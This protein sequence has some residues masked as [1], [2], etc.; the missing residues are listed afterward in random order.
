M[1]STP[2]P[3]PDAGR[4]PESLSAKLREGTRALHARAERA[5]IMP[6]LLRGTIDR[7]SYCRLLWCLE[8]IYDRLETLLRAHAAQGELA[9]LVLPDLFR[10]QALRSDL[11][12]LGSTRP[13]RPLPAGEA[14]VRRLDAI[15]GEDPGLLRAHV[16]V[17]YLGDLSGG[18]ILKRLVGA[19]PVLC[20]GACA[21]YEFGDAER[22]RMLVA[23]LRG[24]LEH[25]VLAP[26]RADAIVDEARRAFAAHVEMF[27]ALSA[28]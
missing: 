13:P 21:F 7:A 28:G 9:G 20:A 23:R 10:T 15:A 19:N 6:A 18:Q 8:P 4:A 27:E 17:R 3:I 14:Y 16:Y 26:A 5:G 2:S 25:P 11:R 24:A 22:V 12:A 1:I